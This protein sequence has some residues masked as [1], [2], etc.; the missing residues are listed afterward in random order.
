MLYKK[1]GYPE[2]DE[3]VTCTVTNVQYNSVFVNLDD[4]GKSALIHI[5]EVSPGRIRNIRDY[6][7]EGKVVVC[8]VLRINHERGHIDV[9]LRRVNEAQRRN[10]VEER[11]AELKAEKIIDAL[12]AD[13]KEPVKELYTTI[14][15]AIFPKYEMLNYAFTDVVENEATLK[16]TGLD[17]KYLEPLIKLV[18]ERIKPKEVCIVGTID[19]KIYAPDGVNIVKKALVEADQVSDQLTIKNLGGG[20]WRVTVTA[21]EFKEAE[22]I[23]KEALTKAEP[24]IKQ[25]GG[26]FSFTRKD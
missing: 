25:A 5:S 13:L 16:D 10:K 9:S 2:I 3:L 11:K 1:T 22:S 14:S 20:S 12:A 23:L 26:E 8:K 21:R 24:S 4:Y 6:V 18:K 15:D 7:K 19:V 17:K